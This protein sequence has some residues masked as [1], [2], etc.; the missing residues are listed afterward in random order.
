[1][2][3]RS[4]LAM[5]AAVQR[6]GVLDTA[7]GRALYLRAYFA[8]K[9]H[10]EDP[11]LELARRHPELFTGGDVLDIGANVGYTASVLAAAAG[12][13][14]RVFAFEPERSNHAMLEEVVR[15]RG[16]GSRVFPVRAAVGDREGEVAIRINRRHRADHRVMTPELAL[17][18][19]DAPSEIVP[20]V[21][22]DEFAAR[23]RIQRVAFVKIDVQGYELPVCEGMSGTLER[24]P[25]ASVAFEYAPGM[26]REL[27][28]DPGAL[29]EFFVRRGYRMYLV[30]RGRALVPW[31]VSDQADLGGAAYADILA[32]RR[33]IA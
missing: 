16:L 17:R 12:A 32:R 24:S 5:Y 33:P 25:D 19:G 18:G 13:G 20:L 4:L 23:E 10:L 6:T 15:S 1:M 14:S 31:A 2:L 26:M 30:R 3:Q 29:L 8:Y 21:S 7:L 9:R 28:F 27:G 11:L 22:V